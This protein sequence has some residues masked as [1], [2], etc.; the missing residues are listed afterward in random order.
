MKKYNV[1][2]QT[3]EMLYWEWNDDAVEDYVEAESEDEAIE[4]A[5]DYLRE[6]CID[7]RCDPDIV[8]TWSFRATEKGVM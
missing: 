6:C 4:F 8:D 3:P 7:N 1:S 5:K 2:I